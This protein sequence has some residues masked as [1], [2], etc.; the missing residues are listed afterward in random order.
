MDIEGPQAYRADQIKQYVNSITADNAEDWY[1]QIK[2]CA[3]VKS[4][5]GGT[6]TSFGEF[7]LQLAAKNPDIV[8]GYLAKDDGVPNNF[9]PPILKGLEE[10]TRADVGLS[11]VSKWIEGG[12]HL[13]A[14]G[15]YLHFSDKDMPEVVAELGRQAVAERDVYAATKVLAV[16]IA[17]QMLS[18]VDD[19]FVPL[20]RMLTALGATGWVNDVWYL[21]TMPAFLSKLSEEQSQAMLD[22]MVLV[23]RID[24]HD[25]WG[26]AGD[27]KEISARRMEPL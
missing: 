8:L 14:I 7:L 24:T 21:K 10:S 27:R 4:N 25:E 15:H 22:G 19:T 18:L 3:S 11:L 1:E 5:D 16:I 23:D 13:S 2:R 6:F 26:A 17:R 9:L 12:Q 20:V